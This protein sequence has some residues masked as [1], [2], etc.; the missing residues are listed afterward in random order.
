MTDEAAV[1]DPVAPETLARRAEALSTALARLSTAAEAGS[2][3]DLGPLGDAVRDLCAALGALPA[4]RRAAFVAPLAALTGRLDE[5][6]RILQR[7]PPDR[8]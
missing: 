1:A 5:L 8:G 7:D 4:E 2:A 3:V 6:Q